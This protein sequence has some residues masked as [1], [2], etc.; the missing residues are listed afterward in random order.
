MFFYGTG[1][2]HSVLEN[3]LPANGTREYWVTSFAWLGFIY[4]I[5]IDYR[6]KKNK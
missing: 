3:L 1:L 2:L 6:I 4:S 5:V